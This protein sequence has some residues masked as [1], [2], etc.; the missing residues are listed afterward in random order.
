MPNRSASR[1]ALRENFMN[2]SGTATCTTFCTAI[3]AGPPTNI[4]GIDAIFQICRFVTFFVA[5]RA[6]T[7]AISCAMIPASS[8]SHSAAMIIPTLT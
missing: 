7:C 2:D 1:S 4:N 8:A 5:C 6:A 3:P